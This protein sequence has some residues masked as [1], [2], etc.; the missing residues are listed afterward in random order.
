MN[1]EN[2]INTKIV[3]NLGWT[4]LHSTWQIALIAFVLF[5]LLKIFRASSANFRYF[6][7]VFALGLAVVLSVVTF[8]RLTINS[9]LNHLQITNANSNYAEKI[10][11]DFRQ[12][13]DF[14]TLS[15]SEI[16]IGETA[17]ENPIFSIANLQNLFNENLAAVLPLLVIL[18]FLGVMFFALRLSGGAWQIHIYKTRG[19]SEPNDEWLKKFTALCDKLKIRQTVKFL[20][21][22]LIETPVV[23]GWLKPVILVPAS[24]FL[25]ISPQQ[26]ET[27]IAHELIHIRRYDALVNLAQSF[28]EITFF[29]H[30]CVWWISSVI[31]SE[32]EFAAD[33][34]VI[35]ILENSHI[36]YASALAN[37]EEIRLSAKITAPPVL[38]A[39][40]G[41]NLMQ[42]ITKILQKNTERKRVNSAWSAMLALA[43][44]S[45]VL[46]TVFSFN[47]SSFVNAQTKMKNKKIAVGFVSIPANS[48]PVSFANNID[49]EIRQKLGQMMSEVGTMQILTKLAQH[50]IP[51]IGF[52]QGSKISESEELYSK[53]PNVVRMWRD[54]GFEIGIG[55]FDHVW[56]YDTPYDEYVA[57]V[58]KNEGVA[59]EILAEK[60]LP[61]RYFSYPYLNT[62]KN[63]EE[64][65]RFEAWL[66]SRGITPVKYTID[67]QEWMYSFAYN[68]AKLNRDDEEAKKIRAE[69]IEYMSKMFDH[70]EAYSQEMFGR[71]IAQTMVLTP[72]LLVADSFDE[73]FGMIEKRGYKFVSMEEALS[74]SAYQTPE[75]FY[76]KAGISWFERWQMAQGGKLLDEPQVSPAVED[77]WK[78]RNNKDFIKPPPPP[79]LAPQSPPPPP[80]L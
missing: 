36:V 6:L 1:F 29:Y 74:D 8:S 32:R 21:S 45:A 28:V 12:A 72:S 61:L 39:A 11:R 69:F 46:L 80:K 7:A 3:E 43:L 51:A 34:A 24:V 52:L 26:L 13:D 9:N 5:V 35:K 79:P 41:G 38:V 73:L 59:K 70:Y 16:Q 15:K 14:S 37:L 44:L 27:I 25:Q 49:L 10:D 67:N 22:N 77:A 63:A 48:N 64:R 40:N 65:N 23:V 68:V 18:W 58:E 53:R 4:L 71:D 57:G 2:F 54:A 33:E 47:T 17:D 20:Q 50:K 60:N 55:N 31:R 19:I 42:R 76:G 75:N 30:P 56:F 62:G 66:A 78:N